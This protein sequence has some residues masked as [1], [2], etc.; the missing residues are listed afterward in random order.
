MLIKYITEIRNR[1]ILILIFYIIIFI[2][3]YF[4]K[5]VIIYVF[6]KP[7]STF[8]KNKLIYFIYTDLTEIFITYFKIITYITNQFIL[9]FTI[10]HIFIFFS[11]GLYLNEYKNICFFIFISF[12][13]FFFFLSFFLNI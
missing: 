4:Y 9:I 2:I 3:L 5:N 12:F 7:L 11:A 13:L 6:I 10:Y 1:F 8:Y